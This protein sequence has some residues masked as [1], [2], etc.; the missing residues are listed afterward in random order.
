ME[1][2]TCWVCCKDL[3]F[4]ALG[5]CG[6]ND[7]CLYCAC[8]LRILLK[9][10]KCP[11]CKTNLP[12]ILITKNPNAKL[13]DYPEL[14]LCK[15]DHGILCDS[16][17]AQ[18]AYIKIQGFNCWL[19]NC[20]YPKNNTMAQLIKHIES[21]KLRFCKICLK[22]R[23]IF[24]WEQKVYT[25][26]D[27]NRHLN[28]GEDDIP[29]HRECLFC[30]TMHYDESELRT[31]LESK[32]FFCNVCEG[33]NY[34]YYENYEKLKTHF[35]KSHYM[36]HDLTCA[37]SKY[38]VFKTPYELQAHNYSFHMDKDKLTKAQ[39][40]QMTMIQ[41]QSEE[42]ARP[43]TEGI[44]F[45]EQFSVKK[46]EEEE[47]KQAQKKERK[48]YKV[49]NHSVQKKTAEIVDYKTLPKQSEKEVIELIKD[50]MHS[51]QK[52]FEEFKPAAVSF[53]KGQV[54][55]DVLF[56]KFIELA[57]PIQG[58]I[59]FP[60]LITTVRSAEKQEELHREYKKY[61][62]SK[63]NVSADGK[64]NNKFADCCQDASTFRVLIDV[65]E[66][67][68]NSR[69]ESKTKEVLYVHPSQLIQMA[70]IVDKLSINDML[71]L[72]YL[73]NFGIPE[74]AKSSIINMIERSN[75]RTFNLSLQVKYEDFFLKDI[76]SQHLYIIHKYSDMC[77]AKLQGRPLK[78]DAKLLKNWEEN[79]S[80][81]KKENEEEE[82]EQ[83]TEEKNWVNVLVKKNA[84]A[85]SNIEKNFPSLAGNMPEKNG[86]AWGKGNKPMFVPTVES[87][88]SDGPDMNFPSL[89]NSFPS[90]QP[91]FPPVG[92]P[93][94]PKPDPLFVSP[95]VADN[96]Q[97]LKEKGFKVITGGK[98]NK[99]RRGK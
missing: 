70:A 29:R 21:H 36:C 35:Q 83:K 84:K 30:K 76:E 63:S 62:E 86:N 41:I 20:K 13:E 48:F 49:K 19:P 95:P 6:H 72:L 69:P 31:H 68:L 28:Y 79:K 54:T 45:S 33:K 91:V 59:L 87:G 16:P 78:E 46:H 85:P 92:V 77:L 60:V 8:R 56:R 75:D 4:H 89:A 15:N 61:M 25:Q 38:S 2:L 24:I 50:A 66:S 23:L 42:P 44:D 94:V 52:S 7:M 67:E 81:L 73:M 82:E 12:R 1:Q 55:A 27:L 10:Y 43:N 47:K 9:D 65:I 3:G 5:A 39:K 18:E 90:L 99:K 96:L 71:R 11:I 32:H 97:Y 51:N 26:Q 17:E 22:G 40:Q 98:K 93:E 58:E 74:K 37:E 14:E 53:N 80:P 57:G 34:I 88:S 64:C